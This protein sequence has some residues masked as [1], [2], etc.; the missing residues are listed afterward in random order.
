M[1]EAADQKSKRIVQDELKSLGWKSAELGRRLKGDPEK[2]R[3]ARR[4]R[5]ATTVTLKWI[6][7]CLVMGTW[8]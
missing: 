3:I 4:L 5:T 7:A 1:Q 2:I 6:A 8:T